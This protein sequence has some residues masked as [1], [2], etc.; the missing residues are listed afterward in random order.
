M[1][2]SNEILVLGGGVAK[3]VKDND[4]KE[5]KRYLLLSEFK[6]IFVKHYNFYGTVD[7][8]KNV[9]HFTNYIK[10]NT[11]F[12][13]YLVKKPAL[14]KK[15]ILSTSSCYYSTPS[16]I[17]ADLKHILDY[18]ISDYSKMSILDYS[19]HI[20]FDALFFAKFF[21]K[22]YVNDI[23]DIF[24]KILKINFTTLGIKNYEI[25]R[26]RAINVDVVYFDPPFSNWDEKAGDYFYGDKKLKDIIDEYKD[27]KMVIIKHNKDLK[28][29]DHTFDFIKKYGKKP[30]DI[31]KIFC[32]FSI[33]RAK[34]L[35]NNMK[36]QFFATIP[37]YGSV[38]RKMLDDVGFNTN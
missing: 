3:Y 18:F 1:Q 14:P 11:P 4:E 13:E 19:S 38:V 21:G 34:P 24:L 7:E 9:Q 30:V 37:S 2:V 29:A 22:V 27:V 26:N 33:M 31:T 5:D 23:D 8:K 15:I 35:V 17:H 36:K 25:C 28:Y 20:G 16:S 6:D 10:H 32:K 12:Y